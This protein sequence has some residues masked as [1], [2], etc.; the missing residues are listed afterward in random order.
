VSGTEVAGDYPGGSAVQPRQQSGAP[1]GGRFVPTTHK[2]PEVT[3]A[4]LSDE[5]YNA[6]GTFEY[7]PIPR[8]VAQHVGFWNRVKVP[9]AIMTRVRVAYLADWAIWAEKQLDAWATT[10]RQPVG[11]EFRSRQK[12]VAAWTIRFDTEADRL[13]TVRPNTI[14][15]VLARPLI[16]AAQMAKYAQWLETREEYEQVMSTEIDLGE[17]E[18]WTVRRTLEVYHLDEVDEL[19]FEDAGNFTGL[20]AAITQTKLTELVDLLRDQEPE[21]D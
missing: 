20:N 9:D 1:G 18:P 7:P 10:D 19:A 17:D 8:S 2:E 11:G 5:D 12:E 3:L 15:P 13:E 14:S 21:E 6:D 16:R 4:R